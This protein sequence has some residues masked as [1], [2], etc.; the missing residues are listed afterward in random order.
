MAD[1]STVNYGWTKP[2]IGASD[3]TWGGKLNADLDGIDSIV[4]TIDVRGM[5]P[6]PPG[7]TGPAGPTGATGATG[8]TGSQGPQGNP[9]AA[10]T[11][12]TPGA[13]GPSAVSVD[14][15]NSARL[16][17]DSLI[18]VPRPPPGTV[19]S[20]TPPASPQ[21]GQLW[22]DG[23]GGQTYVWVQDAN[24]SQWVIAN[25]A[26]GAAGPPGPAGAA[27]PNTMPMGVTDG[28]VAAPGRVGEVMSSIV[29]SGVALSNSVQT[30]IASITLTPG[31]WDVFGEV[32]VSGTAAGI[33]IGAYIS[34]VGNGSAGSAA[35]NTSNT[36]LILPIGTG[37]NIVPVCPC[38]ANVTVATPYYLI[39]KAG[40]TS[41]TFAASGKIWAR[42]AR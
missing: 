28:S 3:D 14:A 15:Q 29:N 4:H 26:Q 7:P 30:Q 23:V 20:D 32:W 27:G 25:N 11:P 40:F 33:N 34:I 18:Y 38:N 16:G 1:S 21:V 37:F 12:G 39:T 36:V 19:V 10:G 17:S 8:A 42:R 22:F 5:T 41:G 2:D 24:S 6:G 31:D 13:P 9:G 35:L